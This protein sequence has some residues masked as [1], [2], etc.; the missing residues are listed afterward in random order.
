MPRT[1]LPRDA[2]AIAAS[3]RLGFCPPDEEHK[4][5]VKTIQRI[6]ER[7]APMGIKIPVYPE[8]E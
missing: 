1:S 3:A 2:E 7:F 4:C 6:R 8:I 5:F